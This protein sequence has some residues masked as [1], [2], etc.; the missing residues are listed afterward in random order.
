MSDIR[1]KGPGGW[2]DAKGTDSGQIGIVE[3]GLSCP[4][5]PV[6]I[7]GIAAADAFDAEDCFGTTFKVKVPKA[8]IIQSATFWDM[9]DEGSQIDFMV[10]KNNISATTSDAAWAPTDSDLLAFVTA[11]QFATFVDHGTG[12]TAELVNI[13]KAYTALGGFFYIQAVAKSTPNIAAGNM[14]RFQMQI[15]SLDPNFEV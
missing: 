3:M 10:F 7:P 8:G 9:D 1:V 15:I 12:R 11:L 6:E 13:G 2:R 4:A 5:N 14:P